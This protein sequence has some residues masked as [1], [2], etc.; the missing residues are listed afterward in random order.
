MRKRDDEIDQQR[1]KMSDLEGKVD[2]LTIE[3]GKVT[4]YNYHIIYDG[5]RG[6][7]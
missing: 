2:K 7:F 5:Q 1:L 3:N 6:G 4:K